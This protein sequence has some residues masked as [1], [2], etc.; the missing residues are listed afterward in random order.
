MV[1]RA[2]EREGELNQEIELMEE[3]ARQLEQTLSIAYKDVEEYGILYQKNTEDSRIAAL[4]DDEGVR[5]AEL[6]LPRMAAHNSLAA[7]FTHPKLRRP[8]TL[9]LVRSTGLIVCIV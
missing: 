8:L 2:A 5:N 6:L 9:V 1:S 3:R 4:I 7:H